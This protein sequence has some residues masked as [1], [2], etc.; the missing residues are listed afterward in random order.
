M[1]PE[2]QPQYERLAILTAAFKTEKELDAW[3]WGALFEYADG[4]APD[5]ASITGVTDLWCTSPEGGGSRDIALVATLT[6][7]RWATCV[8]WS[9]YTGFGCQQGVDWRIN[10]TRKAAISQGL[11]KESRAH[12]GLALPGEE[13]NR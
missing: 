1:N 5:P 9:D 8:A 2:L 7:G 10:P 11:D 12:L 4:T 6:D 13:N 3:D